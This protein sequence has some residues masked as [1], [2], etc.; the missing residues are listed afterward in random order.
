MARRER[1]VAWRSDLSLA[2]GGRNE[3]A[4]LPQDDRVVDEMAG[5]A[6]QERR[7][8]RVPGA[9]PTMTA[10]TLALTLALALTANPNPSHEPS[11]GPGPDR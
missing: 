7:A 9:Q 11:S 6:P 3:T 2:R 5:E 1:S 8:G 10:L 4:P